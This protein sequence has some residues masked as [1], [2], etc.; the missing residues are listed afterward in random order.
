[1]NHFGTYE[2]L[3]K[4]SEEDLLEV[5]GIGPVLSKELRFFL[6]KGKVKT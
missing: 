3:T 1:L 4:A 2:K 5:E 6:R